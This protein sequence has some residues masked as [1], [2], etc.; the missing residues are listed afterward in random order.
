MVVGAAV[1]GGAVVVGAAMTGGA[2]GAVVVGAAVTGGA[3][4]GGV[5]VV[6]AAVTGGGVGSAAWPVLSTPIGVNGNSGP[7]SIVTA[8]TDSSTT[9][10]VVV[11]VVLVVVA[12]SAPSTMTGVLGDASAALS[13]R[14]TYVAERSV[15]LAHA[16]STPTTPAASVMLPAVTH[17]RAREEDVLLFMLVT[18]PAPKSRTFTLPKPALL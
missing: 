7:T 18:V 10:V 14:S 15:L 12:E 4:T 5:V 9:T 13:A 6:G 8:A 17:R 1:T 2:G 3:V 11:V 16:P